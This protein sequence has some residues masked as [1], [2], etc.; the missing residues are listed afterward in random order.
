MSI[1]NKYSLFLM[2]WLIYI[3]G[4]ILLAF[5]I[6]LTIKADIGTAAWEVL[7][8]GLYLNFGLS[9]GTWSIIVGV[10]I[11]LFSSLLMKSFPK[12][13][14]LLNMFLVGIFIDLFM[15]LPLLKTPNY[16]F[17]QL[18]MLISGVVVIGFAISLYI[19]ANCGAG[20]RDSL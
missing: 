14:T 2:R 20:P 16:P 19:S 13:G 8:I 6:V 3:S 18:L 5:G 4:V 15:L 9:I 12:A 1:K 10:V 17:F 7:H 11:I